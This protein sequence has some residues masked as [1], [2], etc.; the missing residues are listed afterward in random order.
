MG[1]GDEKGDVLYMQGGY[2]SR[3]IRDKLQLIGQAGTASGFHSEAKAHGSLAFCHDA[4][5]FC[6][7]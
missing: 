1:F 2:I 7:G 4:T 5:Q 6:C 3:R